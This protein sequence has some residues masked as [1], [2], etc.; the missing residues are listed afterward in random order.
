MAARRRSIPKFAILRDDDRQFVM[1]TRGSRYGAFAIFI[2]LAVLFLIPF[3]VADDTGTKIESGLIGWPLAGLALYVL[4]TAE[5]WEVDKAT[6][7]VVYDRR[8]KPRSTVRFT[9]ADVAASQIAERR[10]ESFSGDRRGRH[11]RASTTWYVLFAYLRDGRR[12]ELNVSDDLAFIER[13]HEA[14]LGTPPPEPVPYSWYRHPWLKAFDPL[15][16]PIRALWSGKKAPGPAPAAGEDEKIGPHRVSEWIELLRSV[17]TDERH[18]AAMALSMTQKPDA[19]SLPALVRALDDPEAR[20]RR[21]AV[22]AIR[23]LGVPP[24]AVPALNRVLGNPGEEAATRAATANALS[25][26]GREA[27]ETAR[28][29]LREA[30][31]HSD[32]DLRFWAAH[33]LFGHGAPADEA[34]IRGVISGLEAP[35]TRSLA[36][37]AIGSIGRPARAAV[38]ALTALLAAGDASIRSE[39]ARALAKMRRYAQDAVPALTAMSDDPDEWCRSS[40]RDALKSV[41]PARARR[42]R[43]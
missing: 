26:A 9:R 11:R 28:A 43:R 12:F 22:Q 8:F 18:D 33:V 34:L 36:I 17:K 7:K 35:L 27:V 4:A 42:L 25:A 39:A 3:F 30:L 20:V 19:R 38:P 1:E 10:A 37:G 41:N 14:V 24:E 13:V 40:A 31:A 5:C 6:G 21:V 2:F 32:P 16:A 15:V 29:A 23:H